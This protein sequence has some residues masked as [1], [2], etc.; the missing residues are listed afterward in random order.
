MQSP[1]KLTKTPRNLK[2]TFRY[3]KDIVD[4]MREESGIWH[5]KQKAWFFPLGCYSDIREAL[6]KKGYNVV[7]F[8]ETDRPQPANEYKYLQK[9]FDE[10]DDLVSLW[11]TC[12]K[13][14]HK[15]FINRGFLST[16]CSCEK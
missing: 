14:K 6:V 8:N 15:K 7:T 1:I 3:N 16:E 11:G 2:V 9:L 12:K 13:C 5:S 4:I 10:D